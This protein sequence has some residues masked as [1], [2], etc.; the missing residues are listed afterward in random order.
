MHGWGQVLRFRDG[1]II[2][3]D[4]GPTE[5]RTARLFERDFL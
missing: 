3:M 5:R 2:D 1:L 4:S